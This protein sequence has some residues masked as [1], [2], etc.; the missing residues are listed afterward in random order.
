MD[1]RREL[2]R[3]LGLPIFENEEELASLMHI[4]P[5]IIKVIVLHPQRF[6]KKY[7]IRKSSGK[8]RSI[9]QPSRGLK[10]IQAWILRSIIEK[11]EPSIY[12]T[13]YIKMKNIYYYNVLQ[14]C[15]NR[16]FM[17]LDLEDFFPSISTRRV[18]KKFEIIGY[19][20]KASYIL[21]RLCTFEGNL[22]QGAV[23]S[24]CLS[25]WIASQLDRRIGGYAARTN[26]IYT[27]YSD[28][29]TL[30]SNNRIL[31]R[32]SLSRIL[33]IIKTEHFTPNLKKLRVMGPGN[34]CAITGLVKNDTEACF[35]IGTK[36]KRVMRAVIHNYV[37]KSQ[38]DVKYNTD[39]SIYGWIEYL[40]VVDQSSYDQM[41]LYINK[42]IEKSVLAASS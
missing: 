15:N 21:S 23:T 36:K 33:K 41:N 20:S 37:F 26:M 30:S 40:R 9:K 25:N 10:G 5:S 1:T 32:K 35:G 6:Y 19:S 8:W 2:L 24:P 42:I 11:I 17:S 39:D 4:S 3:I 29:I 13:G 31:L 28:D 16:Y 14:H 27:R 38:T 34:R 22:P 12:A 18:I 7:R